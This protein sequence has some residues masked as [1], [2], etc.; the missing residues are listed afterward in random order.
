MCSFNN[1]IRDLDL[2]ASEEMDL[3]LKWLGKESAVHAEKIR[4]HKH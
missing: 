2:T 4:A 3:M 1:V